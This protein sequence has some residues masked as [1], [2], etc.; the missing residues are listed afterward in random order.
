MNHDASLCLFVA[1]GH[2]PAAGLGQG[3]LICLW[4]GPATLASTHQCCTARR[5]PCA[6][7]PPHLAADVALL[8]SGGDGRPVLASSHVLAWLSPVLADIL[9]L[10]TAAPDA[11]QPTNITGRAGSR[12]CS[13]TT[14]TAAAAATTAGPSGPLTS[15]P[16]S[17]ATAAPAPTPAQK[18]LRVLQLDDDP[19]AWRLL[20]SVIHRLLEP[21]ATGD[22]VRTTG[23]ANGDSSSGGASSSL[24]LGTSGGDDVGGCG[25]GGAGLH[26]E[27]NQITEVAQIAPG[28]G[29]R[30]VPPAQSA[31]PLLLGGIGALGLGWVS[32]AWN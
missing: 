14:V 24:S 12:P 21:P 17:H 11:P 15:G 6:S 20:L 31:E 27:V 22:G 16:C 1:I 23:A 4:R 7:V 29:G 30:P 3:P 8:C 32:P 10:P 28:G 19:G 13:A 9:R 18:P 5:R 25:G 2:P 26:R